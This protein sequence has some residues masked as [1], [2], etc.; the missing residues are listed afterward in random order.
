MATRFYLRNTTT[1][2]AGYVTNEQSTALPVGT[3]R[4]FAFDNGDLETTMGAAQSSWTGVTFAQTEHQDVYLRKFISDPLGVVSID[5]NTWTIAVAVA[6]SNINAN[7]FIVCSLYV[8]QVDDTVRGFIYDS[9]TPL[10][11]EFA[12][13]EDGQVITVSGSAVGGILATD[14]LAFEFW[15]HAVQGNATDRNVV[16]YYDGTTDVTDATTTDAASYIETPQ[17]LSFTPPDTDAIAGVRDAISGFR[18]GLV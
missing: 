6:E 11:V 2:T 7:A 1:N 18:A 5:A 17:D 14:R 13:S 3:M 15:V 12:T 4:D 16:L 8:L 10:G 9:D